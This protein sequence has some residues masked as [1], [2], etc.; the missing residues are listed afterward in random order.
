[1]NRIPRMVPVNSLKV[2]S[3]C[4]AVI[5]GWLIPRPAQIFY[6]LLFY[7]TLYRAGPEGVHHRESSLIRGHPEAVIVGAGRSKN[8]KF[9]CADLFP[10]FTSSDNN[11]PW[12][13]EDRVHCNFSKLQERNLGF[14]QTSR[15]QYNN[16]YTDLLI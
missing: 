8:R 15:K 2:D 7:Q 12:V 16:K 13:F 4:E 3:P 6:F 5:S 1:M 10:I 14:H 9:R 11:R